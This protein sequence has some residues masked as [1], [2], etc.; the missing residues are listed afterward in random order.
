[1][2]E[3]WQHLFMLLNSSSLIF[4]EILARCFASTLSMKYCFR[5]KRIFCSFL[6]CFNGFSHDALIFLVQ[7]VSRI[8]ME[9]LCLPNPDLHMAAQLLFT[10]S[11]SDME[12]VYFKASEISFS[13]NECISSIYIQ[14]IFQTIFGPKITIYK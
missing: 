1:M 10:L 5:S 9:M 13:V 4:L 11:E 6:E 12:E 3:S 14:I 2:R 7:R 8:C